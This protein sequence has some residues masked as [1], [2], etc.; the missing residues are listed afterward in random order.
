M[1]YA[2]YILVNEVSVEVA[3]NMKSNLSSLTLHTYSNYFTYLSSYGAIW[4]LTY[5]NR[6][7]LK[8]LS[9]WFTKTIL[10]KMSN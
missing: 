2:Q 1:F 4:S 3:K 7:M 9:L 6:N 8:G 5:I 10:V